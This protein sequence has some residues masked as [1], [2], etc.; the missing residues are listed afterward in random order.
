MGTEYLIR[1]LHC[2]V[3]LMFSL[4]CYRGVY[5]Y[6]YVFILFVFFLQEKRDLDIIYEIFMVFQIC[7]RRA[8]TYKL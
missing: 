1:D 8:I 5:I 4:F 6:V 7:E 2:T 3:I